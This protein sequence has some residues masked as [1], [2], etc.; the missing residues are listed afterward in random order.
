MPRKFHALQY[1]SIGF[2]PCGI[3]L[4]MLHDFVLDT[5]TDRN[6]LIGGV[7]AGAVAFIILVTLLVVCL[8]NR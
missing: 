3:S 7:V 4:I 5:S 6:A 8:C 1:L 2:L